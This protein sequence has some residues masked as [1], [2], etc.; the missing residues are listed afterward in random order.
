MKTLIRRNVLFFLFFLLI[1]FNAFSQKTVFVNHSNIKQNKAELLTS[2]GSETILHFKLNSYKLNEDKN[3]K[4][5]IS[6]NN[7]TPVLTLG[8][9]DLPKF[10]QSIIVSYLYEM[11]CEI[12][13]SK[14][15]EINNIDIIPSKGALKQ[16]EKN[17][18]GTVE[19]RKE[20]L[21]NTF[22]PFA[23]VE[24]KEPYI[25]RDFRAQVVQFFPFSYNPLTKVLRIYSDITVKISTTEKQGKNILKNTGNFTEI[26]SEFDKIYKRLFLNYSNR[27]KYTPVDETGKMVILCCDDFTDEMQDFALWKNQRGLETE[28][29]PVS[30]VGYTASAIKNFAS[31]QYFNHNLKYLLLV[32]DYQQIYS[33]TDVSAGSGNSDIYYALVS[34]SDYYPEFFVGRISAQTAEQ[35]TSQVTKMINYEKYP[36]QDDYFGK[37]LSIADSMTLA[38]GSPGGDDGEYDWEHLRNIETDLLGFTYTGGTELFDGDQG[39]NDAV[40]NPI[41]SDV[42]NAVNSGCGIINYVGIG[43]DEWWGT[44]DFMSNDAL[45]LNNFDKY[46]F[47]WSSSKED[48]YFA[49]QDFTCLAEGWMQAESNG[50]PA[51][52]VGVFASTVEQYWQP[53]M[54]AQDEMIDILTSADGKRTY[55]GITYNGCMHMNDEYADLGYFMTYTWILFGDPSLT[56]RTQQPVDMLV[57]H[58]PVIFSDNTQ[59]S[60]NC[61]LDGAL[62]CIS[63]NG[64]IVGK[65]T[66]SGGTADVPISSLA[67]N[68]TVQLVVTGFNKNPYITDLLVIPPTGSFIIVDDFAINGNKTLNFNETGNIDITL[69]NAGTSDAVNVT[70]TISTTD[71]N[72]TNIANNN[73]NF[74][75]ITSGNGTSTSSNSYTITMAE[76]VPDQHITE[77]NTAIYENGTFK[78]N[79]TLFITA[80]APKL[81]LSSF[82]I[83]DSQQG[84]G[85]G[86]LDP[87]ETANLIFNVKNDGH[88][89]ITNFN[90][91]LSLLGGGSE[92]T[93]NNADF[94]QDN[95]NINNITHATFNVTAGNLSTNTSF[96]ILFEATA[97]ENN[98][99]TFSDTENII[100]SYS[101]DYCAAGADDVSFEYI[102]NVNIGDIDNSS[103]I[104]GTYHDYSDIYTDVN[105]G[106]TYTLTV[107]NGDH[108]DD[109]DMG[110]WIDWNYDGDFDDEN[111]T[112]NISYS[113]PYGIAQ[114]TVPEG[115]HIGMNR[116]RIRLLWAYDETAEP[117][118]NSSYGEVEDYSLNVVP[119]AEKINIIKNFNIF[120]YPNP[121]KDILF[122]ENQS[123]KIKKIDLYNISG[124][125]VKTAS[126]NFAKTS[127]DMKNL[128]SGLYLLRIETKNKTITRKIIKK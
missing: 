126:E 70:A 10:S 24:L 54:D 56:V 38:G 76:N 58:N 29:V 1:N 99:Y 23:A 52:A 104:G 61:D 91:T 95:L 59:F 13:S 88:A 34:G 12:I 85:N 57:S 3:G 68:D 42:S 79:E 48:G 22:Y 96:D 37:Y 89:D 44:T 118:G 27:E 33:Y 8:A 123:L 93:I 45:N 121:V 100:I 94:H 71:A 108:D 87:N 114:I 9:P 119:E 116:M 120:V 112:I 107:T 15:T 30:T 113:N 117:C 32:G 111:E 35:V 21:K 67:E 55:G 63:H 98:Q 62:A 20:Y 6:A 81:V 28:I 47:I 124:K 92:I 106:E 65:A 127:F 102:S 103:S 43:G 97:G 46:P 77:F 51:G 16:S 31:D 69:M 49:A 18:I 101:P 115:A 74:G 40:G 90:G 19:Y 73:F 72:I 4:F 125:V 64:I 50:K 14:Y 60:L 86:I 105:V 53:P 41:A 7:M 128:P 84:N 83:D 80:N 26:D 82:Q 110:C 2:S 66:V 5:S 39:G 122:I 109:D 75:N 78:R 11:K 17:K 36:L 25:L